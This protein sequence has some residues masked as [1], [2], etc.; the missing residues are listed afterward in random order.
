MLFNTL[1]IVPCLATGGG[2]AG[3]HEGRPYEGTMVVSRQFQPL[4]SFYPKFVL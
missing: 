1:L 2:E 4:A 3:A